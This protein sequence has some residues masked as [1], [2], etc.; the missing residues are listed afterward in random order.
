MFELEFDLS[1]FLLACL[2][3]VVAAA[4]ATLG[5]AVFD[6]FE[7]HRLFNSVH[8]GQDALVTRLHCR[9][10]AQLAAEQGA[11]LVQTLSL[12]LC[13]LLLLLL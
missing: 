12:R 2:N 3:L 7:Q 10:D 8:F 13:R 1:D 9:D 5:A 6:V 4:S 11:C